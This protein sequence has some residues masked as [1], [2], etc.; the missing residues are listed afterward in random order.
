MNIEKVGTIGHNF[1]QENLRYSF[2]ERVFDPAL[3]RPH[4]PT[5]PAGFLFPKGI[6]KITVGNITLSTDPKVSEFLKT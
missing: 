6:I 1:S 3:N 5:I 2:R 4:L